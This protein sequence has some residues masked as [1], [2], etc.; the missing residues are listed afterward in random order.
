MVGLPE[1]SE[2][3]A[4]GFATRRSYRFAGKNRLLQYDPEFVYA[5]KGDIV[6]FEYL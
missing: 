3:Q 2:A 5:N 1:Y 6:L 4:D